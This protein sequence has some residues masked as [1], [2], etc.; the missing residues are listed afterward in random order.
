MTTL[1]A[2]PA[3]ATGTIPRVGR[4]AAVLGLVAAGLTT[5][6]SLVS[7]VLAPLAVVAGVVSLRRGERPVLAVV[8]LTAGLVSAY[9][10]L[11][12]VFALGG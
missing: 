11:L 7:L 2:T 12:E 9:V 5:I 6:L 3:A 1:T 10:I 8:G 4:I